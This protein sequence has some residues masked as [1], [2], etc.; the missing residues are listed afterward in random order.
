[1]YAQD[2]CKYTLFTL[3][4]AART[5][6]HTDYTINAGS[7]GTW[8]LRMEMRPKWEHTAHL[9]D[10]TMQQLLGQQGQD[11]PIQAPHHSCTLEAAPAH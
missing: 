7:A 2:N 9:Q 5:E 8:N 4:A 6:P 10:A 1:M 11:T 3:C